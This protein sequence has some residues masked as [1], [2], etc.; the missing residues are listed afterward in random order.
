M[1]TFH[2]VDYFSSYL[3]AKA[4]AWKRGYAISSKLQML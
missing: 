4:F 3:K 2:T 1:G